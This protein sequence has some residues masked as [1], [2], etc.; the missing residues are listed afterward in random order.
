M[1]KQ[2]RCDGIVF[3]C[4][5]GFLSGYLIYDKVKPEMAYKAYLE[6]HMLHKEI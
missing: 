6:A 5:S 3:L 2:S 1:T 4:R